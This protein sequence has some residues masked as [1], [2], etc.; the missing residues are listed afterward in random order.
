MTLDN[1]EHGH[2]SGQIF[3]ENMNNA[4]YHFMKINRKAIMVIEKIDLLMFYT[5][6][7][8]CNL[9]KIALLR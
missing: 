1:D 6:K 4:R 7:L 8:S 2:R 5:A 3:F 9:N